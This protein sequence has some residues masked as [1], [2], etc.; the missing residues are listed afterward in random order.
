MSILLIYPPLTRA[1]EPPAGIA[2]LA[3]VLK[4][5]N[6]SAS[7]WDANIEGQYYLLNQPNT[8]QDRW[9]VQAVRN[10]KENIKMISHFSGYKTIDHYNRIVRDLNRLLV[11]SPYASQ[12]S[13]LSLTQHL[14]RTYS[15]LK[16]DDLL[17]F[18]KHP[19]R[20]PFFPFWQPKIINYLSEENP[21]WIGFSLFFLGQAFTTFAMLG[22]LK[23]NAPEIKVAVGGGLATSWQKSRYWTQPFD[24]LVDLWVSESGETPLLHAMGYPSN[25][26]TRVPDYD[27]LFENTY[28]SPGRIVP[29]STTMGC[30]WNRCRFCPEQAEN[31]TFATLPGSQ[32]IRE[33]E[34]L[35]KYEP[36][37]LHFLDNAIP[38][39]FLK[40][41]VFSGNR[42]PWYGY[43]RFD[44]LLAD[45]DFVHSL[46]ESGCVML[47]LGLESGDQQVLDQMNKG[48][49]LTVVSKSLD[50]LH[51]V[52]I[53]TFV[54]LLFGT[55][56]EDFDSARKTREFVVKHAACIDFLNLAI[57]NCPVNS[58]YARDLPSNL[59]YEGDLSMYVEFNHPLGWNRPQIR[60]FLDKEFKR[61][62]H[63]ARMIRN[64][65]Q[66][67]TSNHAA[68]FT[69]GFKNHDK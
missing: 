32:A 68:F 61:Q 41:W 33:I 43:V 29:Y 53:S 44:D 57:F 17:F 3:S 66:I 11:K 50:N 22:W 6:V 31:N 30:Y 67:F 69:R 1:P 39:S 42:I 23:T 58:S 35:E 12:G 37:L 26:C 56:Q 49:D 14:H 28:F 10:R 36:V 9:T 60:A 5:N 59:F 19:H 47:L 54:Y 20:D 45:P 40:Q 8:H 16:S 65:P 64:T 55:P 13:Q 18:A 48:I 15:P 27:Q 34:S 52:G 7:L 21:D 62:P 51:K 38:P 63:I 25:V 24:D 46:A 2:K 4:Q